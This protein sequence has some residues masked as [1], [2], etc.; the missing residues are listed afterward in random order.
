M[1]EQASLVIGNCNWANKEGSLLGYKLID[2]K[3]YPRE[4]DAVRATTATRV[5]SAGLVE[6]V[7]Y[8]LVQ[9][10]E[11]FD[12]AAWTKSNTT[13][14]ANTILSP[15]GTLTADSVAET[16]A[17]NSHELAS[18]AVIFSASTKYTTTLYAKWDAACTRN[19]H[20]RF[21]NCAS[22]NIGASFDKNGNFVNYTGGSNGT[23]DS[24]SATDVGNGWWKFVI[25]ITTA[26][27][28][29][30]RYP[31]HLINDSE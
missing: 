16:T 1:I 7:P 6:L 12:N 8:N 30:C 10:S 14:T 15:I 4:I 24:Y 28:I 21:G 17:T 5:N 3:Y 23:L 26:N 22:A 18:S 19:I 29:P 11:Q 9:Y 25:T 27:I 13:A 2:G 20:I 31:Y